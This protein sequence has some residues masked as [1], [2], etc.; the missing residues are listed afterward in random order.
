MRA[1][2]GSGLAMWLTVCLAE[3]WVIRLV[4]R[5]TFT[6]DRPVRRTL[7]EA[8]FARRREA[9]IPVSHT[10]P[11]EVPTGKTSSSERSRTRSDQCHGIQTHPRGA[12]LWGG[13]RLKRRL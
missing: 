12:E 11:T 9:P 13:F 3:P 5:L 10:L 1:R 8:S 6:I 4:A 2:R 7:S